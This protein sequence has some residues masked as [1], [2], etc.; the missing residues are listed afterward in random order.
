[1]VKKTR[2]VQNQKVWEITGRL[3]HET[4][5]AIVAINV[6]E[7][8]EDLE[9]TLYSRQPEGP[10][11]DEK[12]VVVIC[13]WLAD[14]KW[15]KDLE[16]IPDLIAKYPPRT[17]QCLIEMYEKLGGKQTKLKAAPVRDD[18]IEPFISVGK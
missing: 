4:V 11:E 8:A 2:T 14:I 1:M 10:E 12:N 6:P 5:K 3:R 17:Q 13:R 9:V 7:R 16:D 15:T 18:M